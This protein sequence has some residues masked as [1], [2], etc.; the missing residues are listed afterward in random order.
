MKRGPVYLEPTSSPTIIILTA[1]NQEKPI[2]PQNMS[3]SFIHNFII[4]LRTTLW[5]MTLDVI[6]LVPL[7]S[8]LSF[9]VCVDNCKQV[10]YGI[11]TFE[12][13]MPHVH[14]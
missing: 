5:R 8:F 13:T 2:T 12:M 11:D 9:F 4:H 6:Y 14:A 1:R 3:L 10:E 7:A